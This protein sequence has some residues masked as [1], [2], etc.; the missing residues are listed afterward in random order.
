MAES[1]KDISRHASAAN[2]VENATLSADRMWPIRTPRHQIACGSIFA[3]RDETAWLGMKD[4]NSE[5]PSQIMPL[6]HRIDL[7][8]SSRLPATETIRV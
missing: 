5:T 3:H 6:K 4:S 7:W 8:G 2:A 1:K